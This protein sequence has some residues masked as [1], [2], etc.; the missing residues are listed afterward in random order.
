[1]EKQELENRAYE[2]A[3]TK[4]SSGK[5]RVLQGRDVLPMARELQIFLNFAEKNLGFNLEKERLECARDAQAH[6]ENLLKQEKINLIA[7]EKMLNDFDERCIEHVK[8]NLFAEIRVDPNIDMET[9]E[10]VKIPKKLVPLT[11]CFND[12]ITGKKSPPIIEEI[13]G[14]IISRGLHDIQHQSEYIKGLIQKLMNVEIT[15]KYDRAESDKEYTQREA[16]ADGKTTV[17]PYKHRRYFIM[18]ARLTMKVK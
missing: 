1:M 9:F 15:W 5:F 17:T 18:H 14:R 4:Q 13:H 2:N 6:F 16:S 12:P 10:K 3:R 7:T 11:Y 8:K